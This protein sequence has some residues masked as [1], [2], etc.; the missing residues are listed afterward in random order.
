MGIFFFFFFFF[1]FFVFLIWGG[2]QGQESN[3]SIM[4]SNGISVDNLYKL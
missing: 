3:K 1:F 2:V 4:V